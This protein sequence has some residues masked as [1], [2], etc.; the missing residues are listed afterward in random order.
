MLS[1]TICLIYFAKII[2][3]KTMIP[4]RFVA[5]SLGMQ[6]SWDTKTRVADIDTGNISSGDVVEVTEETTT[7]VAP[8]ITT[9]TEQTTTTETTTEET[10][11]VASTT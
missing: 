8:V 6:V 11:T 9:T 7:T 2:N 1:V 3:N 4:L 5:T 10:T